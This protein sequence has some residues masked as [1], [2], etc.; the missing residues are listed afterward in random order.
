MPDF[1]KL[2]KMLNTL[3]YNVGNNLLIFASM[4]TPTFNVNTSIMLALQ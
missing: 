1:V 3:V 4:C 2:I